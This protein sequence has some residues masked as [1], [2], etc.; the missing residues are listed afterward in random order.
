MKRIV[1]IALAA[2]ALLMLMVLAAGCGVDS[3]VGD[4]GSVSTTDATSSSTT[5]VTVEPQETTTTVVEQTTTTT[6][7]PTTMTVNVYYS[8]N[9]KIC[10]TAR[11]LPKTTEVGAAAVKTLLEGPT[12]TEKAAEIVTNIPEGTTFLGLVIKDGIATVDLSKEYASGG[13]SLSMA[14]RLAEVV[15]TLT[16]FP[17]V[18]GVNFKL[19]GEPVEVFGGEGIVLDHPVNRSDYE[20]L[21]PAILVES[22]TFGREAGSPLRIHGTANVYEAAFKI[23][24]VNWDG[25]VIAEE[26]V[27]ASSG[28][29]ERGTFDVTVPFGL[30]KAGNGT[31]IVFSESPKDGSNINVV[32]IPLKLIK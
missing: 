17:T 8:Q 27:K 24:I 18:K 1:T 20:D 31:L 15:F 2:C 10:A 21:S 6:E 16:Q 22:P 14:M 12:S 23:N 28:T 13:G 9:E 7:A 25:L 29:G 4:G 26:T 11:V 30:D 3:D 32:E 19:D 5:A